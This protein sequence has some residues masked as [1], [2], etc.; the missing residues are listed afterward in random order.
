MNEAV[1]LGALVVIGLTV[2]ASLVALAN[3]VDVQAVVE[4]AGPVVTGCFAAINRRTVP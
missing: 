3:K 2:V 4:I 1:N